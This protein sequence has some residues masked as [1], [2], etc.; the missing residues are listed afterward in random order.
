MKLQHEGQIEVNFCCSLKSVRRLFKNNTSEKLE[1]ESD[2]LRSLQSSHKTTV[3]EQEEAK[4]VCVCV[5]RERR[6]SVKT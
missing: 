6:C 2:H 4:A 5:C 3:W 1:C